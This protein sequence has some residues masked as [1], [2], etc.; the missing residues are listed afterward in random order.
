M[1]YESEFYTRR[2]YTSTYTSSSR[3]TISSYT[4]TSSYDRD[5]DDDITTP[6]Y[7]NSPSY[8]PSY[9]YYSPLSVIPAYQRVGGFNRPSF[10]FAYDDDYP[11]E[12]GYSSVRRTIPIPMTRITTSPMRVY[13]ERVSPVRVITPSARI[14]RRDA[15][16][17][18]RVITSPSRVVSVRVRPSVLS[19]EFDRIERKHRM[20][21][22]GFDAT[23]EWLNSPYTSTFNDETR[24]IR[25]Q[26]KRLLR[27][28]NEPVQ[29][30][31]SVPR[32]TRALSA[33]PKSYS[34]FDR[35]SVPDKYGDQQIENE[36][37]VNKN[38]LRPTRKTRDQIE[39]LSTLK[40]RELPKRYSAIIL[41]P[42]RPTRRFAEPMKLD[43]PA[44]A[45]KEVE[46]LK[47]A[48]RLERVKEVD[49]DLEKMKQKRIEERKL[50]EER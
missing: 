28:V 48:N 29:R 16:S 33:Q 35:D 17:P 4:L 21:P 6:T 41:D 11:T 37:Y 3:P 36:F 38:I 31:P 27:E 49:E 14:Y 45:R 19:R 39:I 42:A 30:A 32:Y 23:D 34:R 24:D 46:A 50:R 18:V 44:E 7:Y 47:A 15:Y 40:Y 20:S 8:L 10:K 25:A 1:V 43:D 2:P 13:R 9:R 22:I 5:F 12:I 26:T